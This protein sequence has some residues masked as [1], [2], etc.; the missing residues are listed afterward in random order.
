MKVVNDEHIVLHEEAQKVVDQA[1]LDDWHYCF[2]SKFDCN[3][4]PTITLSQYDGIQLN[5]DGPPDYVSQTVLSPNPTVSVTY[6]YQLLT[7]AQ[8]QQ[9]YTVLE[10]GEKSQ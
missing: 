4:W 5:I 10:Q 2:I 7:I 1:Q 6:N 8:I 3:R 9:L